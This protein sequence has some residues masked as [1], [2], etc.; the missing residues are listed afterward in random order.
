MTR[1]K[2]D[3]DLEESINRLQKI[4]ELLESDETKVRD[5]VVLYEES[6]D[7]VHKCISELS[8]VRSHVKELKEKA[9]IYLNDSI[10]EE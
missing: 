2:N 6:I 8:T 10:T 1:K 3:F 9:A 5:A 7:L 4:V